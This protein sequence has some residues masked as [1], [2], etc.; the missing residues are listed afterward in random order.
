MEHGKYLDN[1]NSVSGDNIVVLRV[2]A[3]G[4]NPLPPCMARVSLTNVAVAEDNIPE[5]DISVCPA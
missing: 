4:E 1:A 3:H 2:D 5:P